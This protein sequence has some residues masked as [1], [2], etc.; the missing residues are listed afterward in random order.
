MKN[1][2]MSKVV[3]TETLSKLRT[4]SEESIH[5]MLKN[6]SYLFNYDE[7]LDID[8]PYID[9]ISLNKF[10]TQ[11]ED[12][13][14]NEFELAKI[15][16]E[17]LPMTRE[18]ASNNRYW[19]YMNLN[20]F[21]R[22][23]KYRLITRRNKISDVSPDDFYRFFLI[24]QSSQNAF[25]TSPVAG[26]W[27]AVHLTVDH[28]HP[29]DI[30]HYTKIFLSERNIREVSFGT[31]RLARDK[32]TLH[33]ML[34][35]YEKNK[36]ATFN[37]DNIGAEV[38]AKQISK[39][40]NQIGGLTLLGFLSKEEI[41]EKL[42]FYKKTI[43]ER[44]YSGKLDKVKSRKKME[45]EKH[46]ENDSLETIEASIKSS[47]VPPFKVFNLNK[48][49]EYNITD[50]IDSSFDYH[51][52]IHHIDKKGHLLMCY[53]EGYINRVTVSSLLLKTRPLYQNGLFSKDRTSEFY[54]L[55]ELFVIDESDLIG[56]SYIMDGVQYFKIH[57]SNQFK[58][59]ND[60]V[61]LQ[62]LKVI[63]RNFKRGSV[64]FY[65][66]PNYLRNDL[67]RLVMSSFTAS[68]AKIK[69]RS[70]R[71]EYKILSEYLNIG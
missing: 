23:I 7:L 40:L 29:T 52:D 18:Q 47:G 51:A 42:N 10:Y 22:Y 12:N 9:D 31:H 62:G 61:G 16:Y 24:M 3:K 59:N 25:I 8:N 11:F 1:K 54:K 57:E 48:E 30:Y 50:N 38:I 4:F 28:D 41:I 33:A 49:G 64:R 36:N 39:T 56:I 20:P 17:S 68:G 37:D 53:Q 66:L 19:T 67:N 34:D 55:K 71:D 13:R 63:Y 27:W 15:I 6:D 65:I 26:L 69:N 60:I 14:N 70:Y 32:N 45:K 46:L 43:K 44:A 35:F 21:F 2:S 58:D 5:E